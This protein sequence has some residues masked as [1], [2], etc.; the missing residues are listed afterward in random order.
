MCYKKK[1]ADLQTVLSLVKCMEN[2]DTSHVKSLRIKYVEHSLKYLSSLQSYNKSTI[3]KEISCFYIISRHFKPFFHCIYAF[4]SL[5][6]GK[7][8][9]RF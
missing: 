9:D 8:S 5:T 1:I 7:I 4:A 3:L 2:G 6:L